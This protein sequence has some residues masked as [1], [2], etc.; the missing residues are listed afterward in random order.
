MREVCSRLRNGAAHRSGQGHAALLRRRRPLPRR[1]GAVCGREVPLGRLRRDASRNCSQTGR[2]D[3]VVC[4]FLPP[5]VNLP[6]RAAVPRD[7]L[8]AQRRGGDLAAARRDGDQSGRAAPAR[9]SSGSACCASSATRSRGSIS[10]SPCPR[11]TATRSSASIRARCGRRST[12]CR[13]ASTREYFTPRSAA[14]AR[15]AHLVFTGSMDWLPNEDGMLYFVRDILP[16]DP[17]GRA[18]GDAQHHR[19]RADAG[20]AQARRAAR[21]RGH[22]AAWTTC[23]RTSRRGSVYVVPLRIGGGTR[24]KIFEAMAMGKAVVSTTIGAEGL[25][26]TDGAR[27][28]HRRRAGG[29]RRRRSS[30]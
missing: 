14:P 21:R 27:H 5:V 16:L 24:L 18:G 26:V 1:S 23:G 13:P 6:A 3:A 12:S 19:P 4:D 25:P 28:R 2:F 29:V 10:C 8:H 9:R 22:R 30:G 17:P 7:P 15:R 20:R 11:P